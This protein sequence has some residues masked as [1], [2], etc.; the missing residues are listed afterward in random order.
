MTPIEVT[1]LTG[2]LGAG[3]TSFINSILKEPHFEGTAVLVNEFGEVSVDHDLVADISSDLISTTTGCLCCTAS[4]DAK[5]ALFDLWNRRK[6]REIIAFKRVII[7]TTGLADPA[8][9]VAS[10]LA[11]P[12]VN[13]IDRIVATQFA[14]ARVVTLVDALHGQMTIESYPEPPKQVALADMV[15]ITK[16]DLMK[17]PASLSDVRELTAQVREINPMAS[18]FERHADWSKITD[19]ILKPATYDLRTKN[20]DAIDWLA[21][22][23]ILLEQSDGQTDH[24]G[25]SHGSGHIHSHHGHDHSHHDINRHHSGIETSSIIVNE[26]IEPAKFY[27]FLQAIK[28][29][30]GT[31]LLRLK[32]LV[33]LA[34]DPTRPVI[35]HGVQTQV[36]EIDRLN[37]WPSE[38]E[39]TRLVFIG[40]DLDIKKLGS[41][42]SAEV[43]SSE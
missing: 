9:V 5:Q 31:K 10:L 21:A 19:T 35:V 15:I 6:N 13:L 40:I 25:H 14:L 30:A 29:G 18:L 4:S 7:E 41:I 16:T 23:K 39:R 3:K 34:D 17:D 22:E 36:H 1:L 32:G 11:P 42:L 26:P 43:E 27:L 24:H 38:D 2:F 12:S 20:Q 37:T 28:L 8:P 33:K